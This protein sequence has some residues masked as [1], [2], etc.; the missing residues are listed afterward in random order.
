M[1]KLIILPLF[2]VIP[3]TISFL[4]F[5][6]TKAESTVNFDTDV[7]AAKL[8]VM[9]NHTD[10][11]FKIVSQHN[12]Q[13]L[14]PISRTKSTQVSYGLHCQ[15]DSSKWLALSNGKIKNISSNRC[16]VSKNNHSFYLA[17]CG[18]S[19]SHFAS[20]V[21]YLTLHSLNHSDLVAT[22]FDRYRVS[23]Q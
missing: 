19:V 21:A 2:F 13:C 22:H 17:S 23:K 11:S 9:V 14:A 3:I 15:S 6:T 7:S 10:G 4:S 1:Y 20:P 16:L 18:R 5:F 12:D 8:N